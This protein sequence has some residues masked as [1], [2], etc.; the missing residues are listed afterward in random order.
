[1]TLD[2]KIKEYQTA[3]IIKPQYSCDD[4]IGCGNSGDVWDAAYYTGIFDA[5]VD[6]K[7]LIDD[8][9]ADRE[10]LK[11]ALE[12]A[13]HELTIYS[14]DYINNVWAKDVIDKIKEIM[15]EK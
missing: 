13:I 3:T 7:P 4:I 12:R 6:L 9:I 15:G 2:E 10:R 5:K 14:G 1:M 8:L 11:T